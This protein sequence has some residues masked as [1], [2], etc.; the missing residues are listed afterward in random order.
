[1]KQSPDP[2]FL[3][4]V[5]SKYH[6]N[7][8]TPTEAEMVY[9][10]EKSLRGSVMLSFYKKKFLVDILKNKVEILAHAEIFDSTMNASLF[11]ALSALIP[12]NQI[13]VERQASNSDLAVMVAKILPPL[14]LIQS[15]VISQL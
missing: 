14:K 5:S 2:I 12:K 6:V 4:L 15:F 9:Q 10:L 8:D 3:N 1:M 11:K 13:S 7:T